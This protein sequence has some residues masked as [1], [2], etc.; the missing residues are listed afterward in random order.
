MDVL[1]AI[2]ARRSVRKYSD[3]PIPKEVIARIV[4]CARF[5]PTAR[6]EEPWEFIAVTDRERLD[7]IAGMTDHGKFIGACACALVVC[8]KDT[9]YYLEDG[10]AATENILVGAAALG[11]GSCWVAGDKKPYCEEL[12]EFLK[13]PEGYKLISILALGYP[14][15]NAIPQEKRPLQEMLHW[16]RF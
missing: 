14:A 11:V 12:L 3:K 5:A 7:R 16:E 6:G 15:E 10:C 1:D 9:K 4:D 8:C 13:V 2:R